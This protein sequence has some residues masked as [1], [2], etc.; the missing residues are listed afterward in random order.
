MK[1]AGFGWWLALMIVALLGG[2]VFSA[3]GWLPYERVKALADSLSPD[4][5]FK[6]LTPFAFQELLL[7]LRAGGIL[8]LLAAALA[9]VF[10]KGAIRAL[11]G[12]PQVVRALPGETW[13]L[14]R[15]FRPGLGEAPY[16]VGVL[17]LTAGAVLVRL[18]FLTDPM[19]HDETYTYIAFAARPWWDLLSDYHLPNNHIFHTVLVK[20]STSAFG[21]APW[22]VRLPALVTGVLCVP[23]AY[24]LGKRLY[25]RSVGLLSAGLLAALPTWSD[26]NTNARGYSPMALFSLL[27]FGLAIYLSDHKNL[28]G[29]LAFSVIGM[30]G[31]FT[32]PPML[33]P[34]GMALAYLLASALVEGGK[35]YGGR[36]RLGLYIAAFAILTIFLAALCYL[37]VVMGSGLKALVA[38]PY[39]ARLDAGAFF[40]RLGDRL[41]GTWWEWNKDLPL[42]AQVVL[43]IGLAASF[44][45]HPRISRV[46]ILPQLTTLAWLAVIL[47]LQR[48]DPNARL[49]TFLIPFWLVWCAG[50]LLGGL[51][52]LRVPGRWRNLLVVLALVALAVFSWQRTL[53]YF[54]GL[55]PG[56]GDVETIALYLKPRLQPGDGVVITSDDGPVLWYYLRLHGMD[57]R[58]YVQKLEERTLERAY[59][60]VSESQGQTLESAAA[61]RKLPGVVFDFSNAQRLAKIGGTAVVLCE[62]EYNR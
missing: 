62:V 25:N 45:L 50:G 60:L 2:A 16:L 9:L 30:L 19:V 53:R 7:P 12:L 5:N 17:A 43:G 56:P 41:G 29:W 11:S 39:V 1:R 15:V 35:A 24:W 23:V 3:A 61:D 28:A 47:V 44:A 40:G 21:M 4:G 42:W 52:Q 58:Y 51:E 27:L 37:P 13:R 57:D 34:F 46:R 8:L 10:R 22:A 32:L 49:W 18:L 55:E 20:I 54:P 36:G 48:P 38:N 33:Y 26:Y 59:I 6:I 31:F 14:V